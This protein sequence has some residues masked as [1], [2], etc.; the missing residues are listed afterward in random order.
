MAK[1]FK[2]KYH[3][4]ERESPKAIKQEKGIKHS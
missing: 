2:N 1:N 3:D 4:E